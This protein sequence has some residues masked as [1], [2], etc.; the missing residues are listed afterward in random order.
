MGDE[1][2]A[3]LHALKNKRANNG[4]SSSS[5]G[6][7]ASGTGRTGGKEEED[8]ARDTSTPSAFRKSLNALKSRRIIFGSGGASGS[9]NGQGGTT[10]GGGSSSKLTRARHYRNA[11]S[12]RLRVFVSLLWPV[13]LFLAYF[14]GSEIWRQDIL[15]FARYS[16]NEVL[17]SK[18]V[19][20]RMGGE[21]GC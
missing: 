15:T 13:G 21:E 1:L 3:A 18:Q 8:D 4:S 16:R 12:S 11:A 6:Y 10:A 5:S 17:W 19:R 14:V 9:T 20:G 2:E 7:A